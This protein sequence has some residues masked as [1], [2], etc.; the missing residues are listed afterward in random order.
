MALT[1][2]INPKT[3]REDVLDAFDVAVI[4]YMAGRR[5]LDEMAMRTLVLVDVEVR[6][7]YSRKIERGVR[8]MIRDGVPAKFFGRTA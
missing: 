6:A 5:Q 1:I 2:K 8:N 7:S 4:T 3:V